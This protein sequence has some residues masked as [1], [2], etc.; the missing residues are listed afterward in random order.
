MI[1][2]RQSTLGGPVDSSGFANF[3]PASTGSLSITTTGISGSV[4]FV[5]TA[6]NGFGPL[7]GVDRVGISTS[8]L[9]WSSLSASTTNFLYV[10]I[11]STGTLTTGSTTTACTYQYGGSLITTSGVH[12]FQIQE[13]KMMVGNGAGTTQVWRVFVGEATTSGSAVTATISYNYQGR[14]I[15]PLTNI[16]GSTSNN[17]FDHKLG[18]TLVLADYRLQ[19]VTTDV[20]FPVGSTINLLGL[21]AVNGG[22]PL[23]KEY[24]ADRNGVSI[25]LDNVAYTYYKQ[26]AAPLA[27][28]YQISLGSWKFLITVR[29]SW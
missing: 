18:Q 2:I 29:R 27:N 10:E 13:M 16:P 28:E 4:P 1:P 9:V 21:Q 15:S 25:L 14:Y 19:C 6:A 20:G 24:T 8:N 11:S 17:R 3:L 5:A 26:L 7:G 22:Y 23:F 12:V